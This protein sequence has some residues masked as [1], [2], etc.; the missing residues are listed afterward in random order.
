MFVYRQTN[1][2]GAEPPIA[3]PPPTEK[4]FWQRRRRHKGTGTHR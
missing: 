3:L 2:R 1:A 4:T